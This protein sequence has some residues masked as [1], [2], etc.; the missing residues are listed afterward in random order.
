MDNTT[1]P[2]KV[3]LIVEDQESIRKVFRTVLEGAGFSVLEADDGQK[4]WGWVQTA[5]PDLIL[6]DLMMP[7][8]NGYELLQNV[9]AHSE[10]QAIPVI[11]LTL[12]GEEENVRKAQSM[13]ANGFMMKGYVSPKVVV[14]KIRS[15]IP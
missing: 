6:T 14:E 7:F 11:I 3:I 5:K 8:M 10:T 4:G 1:N 13:G 9:K 2:K 12:R 15:L